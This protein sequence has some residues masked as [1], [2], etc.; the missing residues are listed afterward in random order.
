MRIQFL[1]LMLCI[2]IFAG[3]TSAQLT[4][5]ASGQIRERHR[6]PLAGSG[7]SS[8]YKL[9]IR[10]VLK[11]VGSPPGE[12]GKVIVRFTLRNVGTKNLEIPVSPNPG[13]F[14]PDDP[15]AS[16]RLKMMNL[17]LTLDTGRDAFRQ[18]SL[19]RGGAYLYGS[20]SF[21]GTL[22]P[23]AP[24]ESI[25]VL[26]RVTLP[27]QEDA[28]GKVVVGRVSLNDETVRAQQGHTYLDSVEIGSAQSQDY[29]LTSLLALQ[30]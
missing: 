24:D 17:Y 10:L 22:V 19:L 3:L 28:S 20:R 27:A 1:F 16:Y 12:D 30:E 21:P 18:R 13:D 11:I 23:L 8:G 6:Q 5:D 14:E 2:W 7:G 29:S 9:P 15:N 4:V 26:A 25:D